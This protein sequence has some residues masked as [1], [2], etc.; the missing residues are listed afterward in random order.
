M[1]EQI[2]NNSV[3][4]KLENHL[5]FKQG[6]VNTAALILKDSSEGWR[7]CIALKLIAYDGLGRLFV[8]DSER[9][10]LHYVEIQRSDSLQAFAS[11]PSTLLA[12]RK[13]QTVQL[14]SP[15][16]FQVL[17]LA[18][19]RT[20]RCLVL[21]G[22]EA[23]IV[24]NLLPPSSAAASGLCRV[25][26]VGSEQIFRA[27]EGIWLRIL[28]IA[29]HP[30]SDTHLG[31]LSSDGCFRLFDLSLNA[32][33][34]EQE[35]YLQ[36]RLSA[37]SG[38]AL[39]VRPTSFA[40]GGEHL[41][42]RFT[43]FI[44]YNDG[45]VFALCPIVPFSSIY[46]SVVIDELAR[47]A[48]RFELRK[49]YP[50]AS[51]E[52]ASLA[53]AWL[54]AVFPDLGSFSSTPSQDFLGS[55][56]V[57]KAHAHVPLDASL[58]L[59]GPFPTICRGAAG[60]ERL[61]YVEETNAIT[62]QVVGL[63]CKVVGKDTVLAVSTKDG[64]VQIYVLADE[65]QPAWDLG[66]PPQLTVDDKG[67][68]LAVGMLVESSNADIVSAIQHN[69]NVEDCANSVWPG[70]IPPLLQLAVVDLAL[71]PGVVE[72]GPVVLFADPVV[73]ERLYCQHAAGLDVIL[74]QWLPFSVQ[75]VAKVSSE[76]QCPAV[77]PILDI[78]LTESTIPQPLLGVTLILD[79][80]GESWVVAVTANCEC[81]VVNMKPQRTLPEPLVLGGNSKED[82]DS[83]SLEVGVF[84][85][86]SRELLNGPKDIPFT[87][88]ISLGAPLSSET[89]EGRT[90]LHDQCK[91]L[92]EKY[93]EYAHRVHVELV[94]HGSRLCH[95]VK[96]QQHLVENA[97][98][99]LRRSQT[100]AKSLVLRI[101][102]ALLKNR[103]L[104][105]RVRL[106]SA[107]PSVSDKPFTQSERK[108]KNQLDTMRLQDIDI[109]NSAVEVLSV[110]SERFLGAQTES[111][112]KSAF[113]SPA[114]MN[115]K[116]AIPDSQ[117]RRLKLAVENL[118]QSVED[119]FTKVKVIDES[120][121]HW[122]L[123]KDR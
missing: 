54:E 64:L 82:Q 100:Q 28:Q 108:F 30:H 22:D 26:K 5:V 7:P 41:W 40:F 10:Q 42:D 58:S 31:V 83:G 120:V 71:Q 72:V 116:V 2:K 50:R 106:C 36:P 3:Y 32:E 4:D 119:S 87:Q 9:K 95:L 104:E 94:S 113:N 85:M 43:I 88:L 99:K 17:H 21:A 33:C 86:M 23:L 75:N 57:L 73:P 18:F 63:L 76:A 1:M 11:E 121:G 68:I 111:S 37:R 107:L 90:F 49:D 15:V 46:N 27:G 118:G 103:N 109:L 56:F 102:Q 66:K 24:L 45:S 59:Q 105:Q 39:L 6:R 123:L 62:G 74:V 34:A 47:D 51:V 25:Q 48:T 89:I 70:R 67:H 20:G 29:W 122:E 110:R 8:W 38:S 115:I 101:E 44:L 19:N 96:E 81:V 13:F 52:S 92:R 93:I 117:M 16:D 61:S 55:P 69:G 80:L 65:V 112:P 98:A 78:Y 114:G 35:Y 97:E 84:Q 14:S 91:L 77:F 79:S 12:S 60:D 53:L